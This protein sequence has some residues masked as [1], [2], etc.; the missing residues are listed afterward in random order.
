MSKF[1]DIVLFGKP[2]AALVAMFATACAAKARPVFDALPN[3]DPSVDTVVYEMALP[4][5]RADIVI[6]HMDG[7]ATVIE[8]KDGGSGVTH[9]AQGI[10]QAC[11]YATQ[12]ML[13]GRVARVH[14]VLMWT[15]TGVVDAD[16]LIDAACEAAG[17]LTLPH[18]TLKRHREALA[19]LAA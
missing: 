1:T 19:E 16:M 14:K 11:L 3:F 2:E 8:A 13:K 12:L 9:V 10:G 17:V 5:G 18:G 4:F 7:S 15:P 6:F